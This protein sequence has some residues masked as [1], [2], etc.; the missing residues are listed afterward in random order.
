MAVDVANRSAP[1]GVNEGG[2][3]APA[4]AGGGGVGPA[5]SNGFWYWPASSG[6]SCETPR[7]MPEN[8]SESMSRDPAPC[9]VA[10]SPG[11]PGM[12][13]GVGSPGLVLLFGEKA[14]VPKVSEVSMFMLVAGGGGAS[15]APSRSSKIGFAGVVMSDDSGGGAGS[16]DPVICCRMSS[17]CCSALLARASAAATRASSMA[18]L[19][20]SP[21]PPEDDW[22]LLSV[23]RV[24]ESRM[25]GLFS[26]DIPIQP[27]GSD[28]IS[29]NPETVRAVASASA[30]ARTPNVPARAAGALSNTSLSWFSRVAPMSS[31]AFRDCCSLCIFAATFSPGTSC[32]S[33]RVFTLWT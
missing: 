16:R 9:W 13:S 31:T 12:G 7:L 29:A 18:F 23:I 4:P 30:A 27:G 15:N 28:A 14:G 3:L 8:M 6:R 1:K 11:P 32:F 10:A 20:G 26:R 24:M 17:N 22:P 33:R 2:P 19:S 5:S 21:P 25:L